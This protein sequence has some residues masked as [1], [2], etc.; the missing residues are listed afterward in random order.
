M[1]TIKPS[2]NKAIFGA[3]SMRIDHF[4]LYAVALLT[5]CATTYKPQQGFSAGYSDTRLDINVFRVAFRSN[6]YTSAERAEDLALLRSAEITLQNGFT[7]FMY[8][9]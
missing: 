2:Y 6:A 7:H 1:I 3:V 8:L 4:I 9:L 5:G